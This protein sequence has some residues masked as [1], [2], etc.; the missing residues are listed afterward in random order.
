MNRKLTRRAALFA[1]TIALLA[2]GSASRAQDAGPQAPPPKYEVNRI[3]AVPHPGPPPIPIPDIIQ[4]FAANEDAAKKAYDTYTFTQSIRMQEISDPGGEFNVSGQVYSR[5][6][7]QRS[8]RVVG[9]PNSTLKVTHFSLED[10]RQIASVPLFPLTSDQVASY[11]FLYAGQQQLDQINTYAFQVKPKMLDR[12]KRFFQGV[13]WV[14]DH[15]FAIVKSYG[16]FVSEYGENGLTLPFS[17]FETYREN[18]DGKYWLPTYIRSDEDYKL[19][20]NQNQPVVPA[21]GKQKNGKAVPDHDD[22]VL[23]DGT[24]PAEPETQPDEVVQL[25]LIIH[26][27]N[28]KVQTAA[29]VPAASTPAPAA[30]P[31][32]PSPPAT[33]SPAPTPTPH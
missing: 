18:I 21:R 24:K 19:T 26:A 3:S 4:K 10:V 7:G 31:S 23:S 12:K 29:D 22:T 20:D 32:A 5:P 13:I 25:R 15:D 11:S 6:D 2:A 27:T 16:K 33:Q 8:L 1:V 30:S 14:D 28:F 9:Q 17:M